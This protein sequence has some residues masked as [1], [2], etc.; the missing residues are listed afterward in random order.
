MRTLLTILA[1]LLVAATYHTRDSAKC[2]IAAVQNA[3]DAL[4]A[5]KSDFYL[6]QNCSRLKMPP[7]YSIV[8]RGTG[9]SD[10]VRTVDGFTLARIADPPDGIVRKGKVTEL[11]ENGRKVGQIQEVE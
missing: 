2:G 9:V 1:L 11:W 5:G 4:A 6:P 8:S 7:G 3:L 10:I